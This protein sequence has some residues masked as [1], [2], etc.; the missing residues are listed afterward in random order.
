M[1]K[2]LAISL[3][4][5]LGGCATQQ[6][7]CSLSSDDTQCQS[8]RILSQNDLMQAKVWITSG[9]LENLPLALA[10]LDRIHTAD[11]QG[12]VAFYRALLLLRSTPT[13]TGSVLQYLEKAADLQHPH[14]TALLYRVYHEPYLISQQDI[15]KADLY[16][17][18]YAQLDV[19]RSGYPSF[20][21]AVDLT[22][23]LFASQVLASNP[24]TPAPASTTAPEV[25]QKAQ[26]NSTPA[27]ST[28][29]ASANTTK[30]AAKNTKPTSKTKQQSKKTEAPKNTASTPKAASK[31]PEEHKSAGH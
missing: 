12:E 17:Q 3:L 21:Q 31:A 1:R 14:A 4:L 22:H 5:A 19:A 30:A 9:P 2:T 18:R 29:T 7:D 26:P 24:T 27:P 25:T 11:Y 13:D 28:K 23:R 20:E 15:S 16:Q 10:L 8:Q 6:P